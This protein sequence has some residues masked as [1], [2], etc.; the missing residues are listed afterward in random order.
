[1]KVLIWGVS[2]VGKGDVGKLLAN[3]LHYKF[4]DMNELIK[5]KYGT[6]DKFHESFSNDYDKFKS[7]EEIALDII[8][9]NDNFIMT[10]TLIWI[11]E[12][13]KNITNTDTISVEL[14]DSIQS[15]FDRILFYD[16]NDQVCLIVKNIV[17][18]IRVIILKK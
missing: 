6:I 18:N 8:N 14:I 15:I 16:E 9:N 12:I 11:E 5:E 7:K 13:V 3:K 1:M 4:F 17:I 10:I 2:C